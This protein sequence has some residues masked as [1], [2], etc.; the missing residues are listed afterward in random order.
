MKLALLVIAAIPACISA[1][2]DV[3]E[4]EVP[5]DESRGFRPDLT[6]AEACAAEGAECAMVR[7]LPAPGRAEYQCQ[8]PAPEWVSVPR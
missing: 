5:D 8:C 2:P 4:S 1:Q 3:A 7:R 6:T